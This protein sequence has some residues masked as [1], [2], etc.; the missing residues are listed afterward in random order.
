MVPVPRWRSIR[1]LIRLGRLPLPT[2]ALGTFQAIV[3]GLV[4]G[5]SEFLPI[6]S[7]AHLILV[8]VLS[9]WPHQGLMFDVAV[10]VGTLGAVLAYFRAELRRMAR[11]CLAALHTGTAGEDARLA[12]LVVLGTVPVGCAGLVLDALDLWELRTAAAIASANV[13]FALLLWWADRTGN[14][15]RG[16][17]SLTWRDAAI[18]GGAQALALI[19]GTSRSGVTITAA[20]AL[21][22]D[23]RAAARFSFLLS[24]P[25]IAAAGLLKAVEA[26]DTP[27]AVEWRV[28][29][30]GVAVSALSA[31]LTIHVFLRLMERIGLLP[32]VLYRLILGALLFVFVV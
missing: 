17:A 1:R 13:G 8:P 26:L 27:G 18:I 5:L 30:I 32:F 14:R 21:G 24:I 9:R 23:R 10:H 15:S 16:E 7:S 31:Y 4:Q 29:A 20:L 25:V 6:S 3:L 2:G 11:A 28:L 19:P 22:L 12:G